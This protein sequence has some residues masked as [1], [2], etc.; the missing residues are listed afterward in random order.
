M[1]ITLVPFDPKNEELILEVIKHVRRQTYTP[2]KLCQLQKI[3]ETKYHYWW[4]NDMKKEEYLLELFS[5]DFTGTFNGYPTGADAM[6]QAKTSKWCNAPMVTMHLGHQPL[7]WLIDDDHARG[8]FQYEDHMVYREDGYE[9][10]SWMVYID[11][12]IRDEEGV[13][14]IQVMRMA[15]KQL[16]GNYRDITPPEGWVPEKWEEVDF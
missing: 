11:D 4:C 5:K 7:V 12:F 1:A 13:W 3:I 6:A 14:H 8:I 2:E 15:Q 16:D 10:R 9:V